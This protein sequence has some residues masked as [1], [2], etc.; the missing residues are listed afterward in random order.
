MFFIGSILAQDK[1]ANQNEN[2][3]SI[4]SSNASSRSWA[5]KFTPTSL[6]C[7][8]INF[9]YEMM[10]ADRSSLEF[11]AGP[12]ISN[13]GIGGIEVRALKNDLVS[14][15]TKIGYFFSAAYRFYPKKGLDPMSKIYVSPVLKF[16]NY[17]TL[18]LDDLGNVD[19]IV[20]NNYQARLL[21]NF[22][23][24][25][26]ASEHFLFDIYTGIGMGYRKVEVYNP[27]SAYDGS[28][29]RHNW[30]ESGGIEG[31]HLSLD[32]GVKIGFGK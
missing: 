29:W 12:T 22:G 17:R 10:I 32:I 28:D 9:S 15:D 20:A 24:Q 11:S 31:L 8:E 26:W 14:L 1:K 6:I 30:Q 23:V 2:Q 21:F 18:L 3:N 5:V 19:G 16:R 13:I 7:G 27:T 4:E 25:L